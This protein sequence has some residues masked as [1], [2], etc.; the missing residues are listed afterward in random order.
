MMPHQPLGRGQALLLT[1]FALGLFWLLLAAHGFPP[2]SEDDLYFIGAALNLAQGG[3]FVNPLLGR[4]AEQTVERF[5]VQPPFHSYVLAGWLLLTGISTQSLLAFQALCHLSIS[6]FTALILRAYRYPL[7]ANG[8]IALPLAFWLAA[9]G[10][11]PEALAM[12]FL[13]AGLWFLTRDRPWRYGL[14]FALLGASL[15]SLPVNL[16]F[17]TALG[18]MLV[19]SQAWQ[20]QRQQ[21]LTLGYGLP[22]LAALLGA[23][24]LDFLLLLLCLQFRLGQFLADFTWHAALRRA[25]L[26]RFWEA[27]GFLLDIGYNQA[28]LGS[29][30]ALYGLLLGLLVWRWSA[31]PLTLKVPSL[32]LAIATPL[33]L[34]AYANTLTYQ[35]NFFCWLGVVLLLAQLPLGSR[36][37]LGLVTLGALVLLINQSPNVVAL[38]AQERTVDPAQVA[39]MHQYI[40]QHPE[41]TYLIDSTTARLAFDYRLPPRVLDW[42]FSTGDPRVQVPTSLKQK[43]DNEVWLIARYQAWHVADL[44][45]YPRATLWGRTFPSLPHNPYDLRLVE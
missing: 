40:Q 17:S 22:R 12:A 44:P 36:A 45:D 8:A 2:P 33:S 14:G 23:I 11:R 38:L 6:L 32:T 13:A 27:V 9:R 43:A 28:L 19:V 20:R 29:L 15:L 18:G 34:F 26:G 5:F 37:R 1:G 30:G 4:W 35:L 25:P 3:E 41:K 7:W 10:L 16:V 42:G 21:G 31:A 24:A 39:M